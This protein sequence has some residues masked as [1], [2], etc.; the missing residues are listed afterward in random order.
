[1]DQTRTVLSRYQDLPTTLQGAA[2][3]NWHEVLV[4]AGAD[5]L[6]WEF[7]GW[8]V[9]ALPLAAVLL[10]RWGPPALF[11]AVGGYT[12]ALVAAASNWTLSRGCLSDGGQHRARPV[13]LP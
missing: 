12:A 3:A 5:R 9:A 10:R 1:M 2:N 11:L 8:V 6:P 4:P 7:A 13:G